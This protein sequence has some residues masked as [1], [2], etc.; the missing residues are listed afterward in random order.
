LFFSCSFFTSSV[1]NLTSN[2]SRGY[3][4]VWGY[5]LAFLTIVSM[6]SG[7]ALLNVPGQYMAIIFG[8]VLIFSILANNIINDR[9]ER[10]ALEKK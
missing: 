7:L 2:L 9:N 1:N 6:R 3:G 4:N 10:K 8:L 5:I